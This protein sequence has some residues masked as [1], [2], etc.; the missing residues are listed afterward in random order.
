M[1]LLSDC[2]SE[3]D[4]DVSKLKLEIAAFHQ[5]FE[6]SITNLTVLTN[7]LHDLKKKASSAA[8]DKYEI[9]PALPLSKGSVGEVLTG[10]KVRNSFNLSIPPY[11]P[12]SLPPSFLSLTLPSLSD[13]PFSLPPSISLSSLVL[14]DN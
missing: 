9:P 1:S 3:Q 13:P 11:P 7:R 10:C 2:G 8:N 14:Q 12:F 4:A 5:S 6:T